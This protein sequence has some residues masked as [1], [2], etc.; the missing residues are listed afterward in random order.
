MG[1]N[2]HNISPLPLSIGCAMPGR[3][4]AYSP[5][6]TA[7]GGWDGVGR[8]EVPLANPVRRCFVP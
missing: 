3:L 8:R 2:H 4:C 7:Q 1:R 5:A 6:D